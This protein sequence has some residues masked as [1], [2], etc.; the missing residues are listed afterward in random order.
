MAG[1]GGQKGSIPGIVNYYRKK[2]KNC[3]CCPADLVF[4][5]EATNLSLVPGKALP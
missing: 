5:F 2:V 1:C 3:C 4:A